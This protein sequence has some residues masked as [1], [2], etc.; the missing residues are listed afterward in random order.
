MTLVE[1]DTVRLE[2]E[3]GISRVFACAETFIVPAAAIGNK[4]INLG[5]NRA[6]ILKA[7]L[8]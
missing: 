1:G 8:K 2:T 7:F 4:L 5:K 6:K 3:N